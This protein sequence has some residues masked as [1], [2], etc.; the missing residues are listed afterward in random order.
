MAAFGYGNKS[1]FTKGENFPAPNQYTKK[2][3]T[4]IG[5][6]KN[7]GKSFGVSRAVVTTFAQYSFVRT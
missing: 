7:K 1:D 4:Q 3:F 5:R 2:S 6:D